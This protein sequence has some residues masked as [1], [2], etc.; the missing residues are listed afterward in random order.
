[1]TLYEHLEQSAHDLDIILLARPLPVDGL[2]FATPDFTSITLNSELETT[3]ARCCVL[4]EELG[5][6]HTQP[7]DLFTSPK[8][9]QDRYERLASQWA[10]NALVPLCALV[11]AWQRGIRSSW[12]LAEYLNVTEPF[13]CKAISLLE[14]RYGPV[15]RCGEYRIHFRPM[16][17]TV[18]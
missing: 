15:A 5:H 16:E 9:T 10:A 3:C 18:S 7:P 17:V 8:T 4:A 12:E 14:Q 11:R 13:I 1:M 6:H 2:Y